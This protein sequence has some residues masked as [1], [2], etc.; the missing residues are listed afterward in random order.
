MGSKYTKRHTGH[1]RT[2]KLSLVER[3]KLTVNDMSR[4]VGELEIMLENINEKL[5]DHITDSKDFRDEI[6]GLL[7][8]NTR[9]GQQTLDQATK[10]NGR[11]TKMEQWK[12]DTA[13]PT[14]KEYVKYKY[15]F[16]GG[17]LLISLCGILVYNLYMFKLKADITKDVNENI[18][19]TLEDKYYINITN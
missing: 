8:E 4:T 2:L 11:M 13:D 16:L 1:V 19:K 10:T 14:F 17:M 3:T 18:I 5:E 7:K 9:I 6:T 12:A 15:I